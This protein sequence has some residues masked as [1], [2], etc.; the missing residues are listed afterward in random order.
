[1][2]HVVG[3]VIIAFVVWVSVYTLV[4]AM[5]RAWIERGR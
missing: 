4:R 1:M 3:V 5:G 2:A